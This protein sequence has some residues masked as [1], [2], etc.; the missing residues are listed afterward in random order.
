M[1]QSNFMLKIRVLKLF[2]SQN[3]EFKTNFSMIG[4]FYKLDVIQNFTYCAL[5]AWKNFLDYQMSFS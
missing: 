1:K 2:Q 5:V 3:I 4:S